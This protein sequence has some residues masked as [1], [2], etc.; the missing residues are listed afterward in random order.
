MSDNEKND[1]PQ[2]AEPEPKELA[3]EDP[4]NEP[5]GHPAIEEEFAD[6]IFDDEEDDKGTG[7]ILERPTHDEDADV[8]FEDGDFEDFEGAN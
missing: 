6:D 5:A 1:A 4:A 8:D 7:P 3:P 2:P